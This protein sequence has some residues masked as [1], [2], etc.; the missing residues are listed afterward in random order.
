MKK[1]FSW[2]TGDLFKAIGGVIDDIFTNDEERQLAKNKILEVILFQSNRLLDHQAEIIK[3]EARG[4][5][6]QKSW[7][8]ILMLAFGFI[9]IYAKFIAVAFGLPNATLEPDFWELLRLGI[10]GYVVGRSAEKIAKDVLNN[11]E[12]KRKK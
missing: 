9:V 2:L 5:W 1:V 3:E 8:P 12:F 10:G 4:N 7:R 6:L 11:V